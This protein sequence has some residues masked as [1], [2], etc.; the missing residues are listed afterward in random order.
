MGYCKQSGIFC[1]YH[2]VSKHCLTFNR[3]TVIRNCNC[4]R[5]FQHFIIAKLFAFKSGSDT[6]HRINVHSGIFRFINNIVYRLRTVNNRLCIRHTSHS[7]K[8][9]GKSSITAC[10]NILFISQSRISEV[11]MHIKK[12]R[13]CCQT[14]AINFLITITENT[15]TNFTYDSI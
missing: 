12:R 13:H 2:A 5:R 8:T 9:S 6:S 15:F 4:S 7:C 11:N 14:A 1:G 3:T 10:Y